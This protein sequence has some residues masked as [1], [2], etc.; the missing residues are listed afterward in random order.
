MP[1]YMGN[2]K[3]AFG[4]GNQGTSFGGFG[5]TGG[6]GAIGNWSPQMMGVQDFMKKFGQSQQIT[7]PS[8]TMNGKVIGTQTYNP[9]PHGFEMVKGGALTDLANA[10][11]ANQQNWAGNQAALGQAQQTAHD[12]AAGLQ[13][14]GQGYAQQMGDLGQGMMEEGNKAWEQMGGYVDNMLGEVKGQNQAAYDKMAEAEKFQQGA[15]DDY[16]DMSAQNMSAAAAGMAQNVQSE[17]N[18]I[19]NDPSIPPDQAKAMVAERKQQLQVQTQQAITPMSNQANEAVTQMKQNLAQMK[20]GTGQSMLQGSANYSQTAAAGANALNQ[21]GAQ[22][23]AMWQ[24]GA[25]MTQFGA[26][27]KQA[28]EMAAAQMLVGGDQQAFQNRLQNPF[29]PVSFF[30]T[31]MTMFGVSKANQSSNSGW[32]QAVSGQ[33]M[34]QGGS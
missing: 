26:Q 33:P 5:T 4:Q 20:F 15:I 1:G 23:N 22:K 7:K 3:G 10:Q 18:Q 17:I 6:N 31:F 11:M 30:D 32:L 34:I 29:Q 19:M 13:Q 12:Q 27:M 28:N 25:A 2:F 8:M 21:A 24:N 16:Q 9:D 14:A